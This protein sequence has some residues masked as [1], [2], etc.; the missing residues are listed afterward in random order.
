MA[1][2]AAPTGAPPPGRVAI[3]DE[4]GSV[5]T[6]AAG[7]VGLAIEEGARVASPDELR[8]AQNEARYG[9]A[10]GM[11]AA[12]GAGVARGLTLGL[13]DAAAVAVGGEKVRR[14]LAGLEEVNPGA[15][16]AGDIIG[17]AAPLLLSGGTGAVARG[18]ATAGAAP[19]I[20]AGAGRMA[21]RRIARVLGEGATAGGRI[22]RAIAGE[23]AAGAIEASAY[24]AG[25]AVSEAAL[26]DHELTAEQLLVHMGEAAAFGGV[27]GGATAAPFALAGEAGRAIGGAVQRGTGRLREVLE[28]SRGR[29]AEALESTGA[30][31]RALAEDAPG[32]VERLDAKATEF[33]PS[34]EAL[35]RLSDENAWRATYARK[36]FTDEANARAGG[37]DKVG[38]V[39]KETGVIRPEDGAI[40]NALSPE[41]ILPRI[42]SAR[43]RIGA[44]LGGISERS[45][46]TIKAGDVVRE[47]EAVIAPLREVAGREGI[48]SSLESY[49]DSLIDKLGA[50][51]QKGRLLIGKDISVQ[52]LRR[53]RIGLQEIAFQEAK[54]LDPGGRVEFLRTIRGALDDL[55]VG[56]LVAEGADAAAIKTLKRQYQGLRIAEDATRDAISRGGANRQIGATDYLAFIG[57][58]GGV[59]GA[60]MALLNKLGRER[61][62]AA[63]SVLL[64]DLAKTRSIAATAK[65]LGGEAGAQLEAL[66]ASTRAT[67]RTAYALEQV[68]RATERVRRDVRDGVR[69]FIE[70]AKGKA[71]K[72][73]TKVGQVAETAGRVSGAARDARFSAYV[74]AYTTVEGYEHRR[75]QVEELDAAPSLMT[76]RLQQRVGGL[77]DHAPNV[78]AALSMRAQQQHAA[79][80]AR[81]PQKTMPAGLLPFSKPPKPR[82]LGADEARFMRFAKAVDYP[83]S[84]IAD[85]HEGKLSPEGVE[86]VREAWPSLYSEMRQEA[87]AALNEYAAKGEPVPFDKELS[88]SFLLDIPTQYTR[89]EFVAAV[90][91]TKESPGEA[92]AAETAGKAPSRPLGLKSYPTKGEEIES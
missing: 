70:G 56:A 81:L 10:G 91:A 31:A 3:V 24:G 47:V 62:S 13:S 16:M 57:G 23:A 69:S 53:Q 44:E 49:R 30:R 48:V 83:R 46:A 2:P 54:S 19:R 75:R 43:E 55:E 82:R 37:V 45:A 7:D 32:F 20:A 61:G 15:S 34:S 52:D 59:T 5:S 4:D 63:I 90:Q 41:D 71:S 80:R 17:S 76:S 33:L 39:L 84:V 36:K 9:G 68:A 40:A 22:A 77:G 18:A 85:M 50:R 74:S 89:P 72:A 86:A 38:R 28:G 1:G 73:R 67:E 79:L 87:F 58:G 8:A 21:E 42:E 29:V 92:G 25:Q 88:L 26:G 78:A 60:S 14:T 6:V 35:M 64:E 66:G 27:L 12:A 65:K 51:S 11:A